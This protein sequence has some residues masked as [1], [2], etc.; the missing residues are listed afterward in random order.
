MPKRQRAVWENQRG[1]NG[2]VS[3]LAQRFSESVNKVEM[4]GLKSAASW[5]TPPR[6]TIS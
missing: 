1:V 6:G 5:R 2:L 4:G 3:A